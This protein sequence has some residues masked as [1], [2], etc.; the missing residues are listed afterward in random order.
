MSGKG[1]FGWIF[2]VVSVIGWLIVWILKIQ[3]EIQTIMNENTK[4]TNDNFRDIH[5]AID[6]IGCGKTR[7]IGFVVDSER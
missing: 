6:K 5:K 1:L 3:K 7:A 4:A 2:G